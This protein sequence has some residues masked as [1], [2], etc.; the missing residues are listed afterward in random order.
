MRL[1]ASLA[2][3]SSPDDD[4]K[5]FAKLV[6]ILS[7]RLMENR[8][9]KSPIMAVVRGGAILIGYGLVPMPQL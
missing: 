2:G 7:K 1:L 5:I 6:N 3:V 4:F 9:A 8:Q